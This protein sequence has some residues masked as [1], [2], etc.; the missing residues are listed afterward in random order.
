MRK[1]TLVLSFAILGLLVN[2]QE[3]T[4]VLITTQF[5]DMK[6]KLYNETPKH[7]EK[8]I[9]LVNE[10]L[11]DGTLFHRIIKEFMVQGGDPASKNAGP[12]AN[13]GNGGPGYTLPAE[14]SDQ[15]IHKKGAL[16][17][18]RLGDNV[19]PQKNSSGSQFYIVQGKVYQE[20]DLQS[21]E[22]RRN[23]S[24]RQ[25]LT[26][27]FFNDPQNEA[28]KKRLQDLQKGSDREGIRTLFS[29]IQPLIDA[30]MA[31]T[32]PFKYSEE[33]IQAYSTLGGTP[34]LDGGYTVFGEIV[35]GLEVIDKIAAVETKRPGD[36][37]LEDVDMKI[38]I[39]K[40]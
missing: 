34:H 33:Q 11:Y 36:R 29:E 15:F 28:Y 31:N 5:G 24:L 16:A 32:T 9:K 8:F 12:D 22:D 19:N 6:A 21:F 40:K 13:L 1:I 37:P 10:V 3:E 14:I 27:Q 30:Q 17:A 20:S 23:A 35:E 18:A 38:K 4:Y 25:E 26:R 39:I 2:A 7:K